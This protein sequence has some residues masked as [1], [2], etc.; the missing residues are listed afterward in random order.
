MAGLSSPAA[1]A[2]SSALSGG[3]DLRV[4]REAARSEI[5]AA[6]AIAGT[7]SAAA[8]RLGVSRRALV[9]WLAQHPDLNPARGTIDT[10]R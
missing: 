3:H 10:G 6:L 4:L 2:L 8:R 7:Q 5:R 1:M 9:S